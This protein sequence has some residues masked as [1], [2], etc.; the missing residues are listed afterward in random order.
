MTGHPLKRILYIED[1]ID[2]Q[3][4]MRMSLERLGGFELLVCSNGKEALDKAPGFAPDMMLVDVMMPG[5]DG[6]TTVTALRA[7]DEFATT[8]VVFITAKVQ[9]HEVARLRDMGA[10]DVI[11]KPFDAMTLPQ[12][13]QSLWRLRTG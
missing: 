5:M 13:L 8:P 12:H 11:S 7:M 9:P 1:E 4:V 2:I 3:T 10:I 6:P